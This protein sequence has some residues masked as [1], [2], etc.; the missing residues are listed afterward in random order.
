[1]LSI[2]SSNPDMGEARDEIEIDYKGEPAEI[3]FNAKYMLDCLE[4]MKE[5][6]IEFHF[7]DKT[8]PGLIQSANHKNH[9]YVIMPMRI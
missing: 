4:V 7:K 8:K 5:N 3:G 6:E 9:T 1:L 2:A